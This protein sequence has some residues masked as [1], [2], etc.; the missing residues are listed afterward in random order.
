MLNLDDQL[1]SLLMASKVANYWSPWNRHCS[2]KTEIKHVL[3]LKMKK[4][5]SAFYVYFSKS[6]SQ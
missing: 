3:I 6:V 1:G 4:M 5:I 2:G